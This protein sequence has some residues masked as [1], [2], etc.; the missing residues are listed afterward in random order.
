MFSEYKTQSA[1]ASDIFLL[2]SDCSGE[3]MANPD[4]PTTVITQV[5][6]GTFIHSTPDT[7]LQILEDVLLGVDTE[8]KV[9][10]TEISKT[11]FGLI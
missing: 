8:G 10:Q 4:R 1:V 9:C 3:G 5:Y 6:R 11:A 2:D 7:A